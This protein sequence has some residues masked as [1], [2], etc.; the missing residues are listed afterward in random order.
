MREEGI[1]DAAIV[2]AASLEA[3]AALHEER[4][5]GAVRAGQRADL[6]L[7]SANPL[8][9]VAAYAN[10]RG[11]MARGRWYDRASLDVALERLAAIYAE[12]LVASFTQR[13]ANALAAAVEREAREGFVFDARAVREAAQELDAAGHARAAQRLWTIAAIGTDGICATEQPEQ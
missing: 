12:P 10:S 7:L 1:A 2:R 9:D 3:A 11:V 5:F 6:V 13:Q 4:E 8:R